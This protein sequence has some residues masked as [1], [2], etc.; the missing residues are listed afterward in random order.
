MMW[1]ETSDHRLLGK[2]EIFKEKPG[3]SS[4][5][6]GTRSWLVSIKRIGSILL[7]SANATA[8]VAE[9][10]DFLMELTEMGN[11]TTAILYR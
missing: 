1:M 4:T 7:G 11:L 2:A 5:G 10:G 9:R 6:T 8:G 3:R